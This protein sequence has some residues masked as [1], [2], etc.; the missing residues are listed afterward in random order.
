MVKP[1]LK[2]DKSAAV[3]GKSRSPEVGRY[4]GDCP[5]SASWYVVE[6]GL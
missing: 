3:S 5:R 2:E 6:L 1:V 4:G